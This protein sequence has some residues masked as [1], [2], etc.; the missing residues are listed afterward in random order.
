[1]TDRKEV[2][3]IIWLAVARNLCLGKI[4]AQSFKNLARSH[5]HKFSLAKAEHMSSDKTQLN[6]TQLAVKL[7]AELS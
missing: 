1:M 5:F 2:K 6:S 3:K 4:V 7:P